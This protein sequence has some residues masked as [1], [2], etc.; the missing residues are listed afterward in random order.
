MMR[1]TPKLAGRTLSA[2]GV[3]SSIGLPVLAQP[4]EH[5]RDR[6]EQQKGTRPLNRSVLIQNSDQVERR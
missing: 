6:G 3:A 2:N 1:E 4:S 5:K